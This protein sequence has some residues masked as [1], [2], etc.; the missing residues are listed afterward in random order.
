MIRL[1]RGDQPSSRARC[2]RT[3]VICCRYVWGVVVVPHWKECPSCRPVIVQTNPERPVLRPDKPD[4]LR[5]HRTAN[6]TSTQRKSTAICLDDRNVCRVTR[7]RRSVHNEP[8]FRRT[9]AAARRISLRNCAKWSAATA[10]PNQPA[11]RL[12]LNVR[13]RPQRVLHQQFNQDQATSVRALPRRGKTVQEH[14]S[15]RRCHPQ[16]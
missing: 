16:A 7:L 9:K 1:A 15:R 10:S 13:I 11:E 14:P 6:G 5:P 4:F 8:P 3:V 12:L 2:R